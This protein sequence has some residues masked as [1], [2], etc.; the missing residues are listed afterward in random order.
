MLWKV[1]F[2]SYSYVYEFDTV[3][4]K[5]VNLLKEEKHVL[6]PSVLDPKNATNKAKIKMM[7]KHDM[8]IA[9]ITM[10]FETNHVNKHKYYDWSNQLAWRFLEDLKKCA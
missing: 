2:L 1:K 8:A 10:A 4:E 3:L 6:D 7:Q 5:E 9:Y